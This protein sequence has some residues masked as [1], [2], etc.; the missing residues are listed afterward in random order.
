MTKDRIR[1]RNKSRRWIERSLVL[2]GVIAIGVWVWSVGSTAVFQDWEGW[3]F[4]R[5][6]RGERSTI[7][8]YVAEKGSRIAA[9]LRACLGFPET[10]EPSMS[11]PHI[12][13]PASSP[14]I[15]KDG[16]VGRLTIPR[17]HLRAMVREG[18]DE[19]TLA[20]ALGHIRGT[21]LP[22]QKGNVGVAGH[23]DKLFRHLREIDKNDLILFETLAGNYVYQVEN[24]EVVKPQNVS[25]L[26][27]REYPELTLVTCYPFNYIGSAPERFIVQARQ[28]PSTQK[29]QEVTG[30]PQEGVQQI[31]HPTSARQPLADDGGV[32]SVRDSKPNRVDRPAPGRQAEEYKPG[33]KRVHFEVIK[34]HSQQVSPGISLGLTGIE[35]AHRRV[36]GWIWVM[37]DRRTIWLRDQSAQ[38]PVAFYGYLDGKRRELVIT[39]VT[40]NSVI[41]YLL[42]PEGRMK[43]TSWEPASDPK[44]HPKERL[45]TD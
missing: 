27:A 16:L 19:K 42:V 24:T 26:K 31:S 29:E 9:E 14:F 36:N 2:A 38:E 1:A 39:R 5:T 23:R 45:P 7:S 12:G 40:T 35:M 30:T 44:S 4:D 33:I 22:W 15:D 11:R 25:V 18:A 3:V 43:L 20:L 13:L 32:P 34:D 28:V 10:R 41:G 37:P 21:A 6:A 8:E 17:L